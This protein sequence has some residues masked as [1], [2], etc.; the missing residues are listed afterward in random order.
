MSQSERSPGGARAGC[1]GGLQAL[2]LLPPAPAA[3]RQYPPSARA[4]S[5]THPVA[6][7]SPMEWRQVPYHGRGL[8][9]QVRDDVRFLPFHRH[10]V[11]SARSTFIS[12]DRNLAALASFPSVHPKPK[13]QVPLSGF[14]VCLPAP[15]LF[16]PCLS[17]GSFASWSFLPCSGLPFLS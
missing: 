16:P 8:R 10:S 3:G 12:Q 5:G 15:S 6:G 11:L 7:A 4:G 17:L 13:C 9:Q 1:H 2:L 14:G